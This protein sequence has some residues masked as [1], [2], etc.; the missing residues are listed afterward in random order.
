MDSVIIVIIIATGNRTM[1]YRLKSG[2]WGLYIDGG[3]TTFTDEEI[4]LLS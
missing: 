2:G 1:V 3:R 4:K